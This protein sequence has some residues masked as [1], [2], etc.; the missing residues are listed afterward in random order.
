MKK[1]ALPAF[2]GLI[3]LPAFLGA[4]PSHFLETLV[5]QVSSLLPA[6]TFTEQAVPGAGGQVT[7]AILSAKTSNLLSQNLSAPLG[8]ALVY[9]E[10]WD[11]KNCQ[12]PM[13]GNVPVVFRPGSKGVQFAVNVKLGTGNKP[14]AFP[15]VPDTAADRAA[16]LVVAGPRAKIG[17]FSAGKGHIWVG[18]PSANGQVNWTNVPLENKAGVAHVLDF[19]FVTGRAGFFTEKGKRMLFVEYLAWPED[20]VE[21]GD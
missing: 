3:L 1:T 16:A 14:T 6:Y 11:P 4:A 7:Q 5:P 8:A 20:P 21:I 18:C 15:W 13:V 2:L 19:G 12:G 17:L 9:H 10:A